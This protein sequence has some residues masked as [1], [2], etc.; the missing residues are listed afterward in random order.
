MPVAF[1][2]TNL[3][4]GLD[5]YKELQEKYSNLL[6]NKKHSYEEFRQIIFD[7][8]EDLKLDLSPYE[9]NFFAIS[10]TIFQNS[11]RA[12]RVLEKPDRDSNVLHSIS[13][14]IL[15]K[16]FIEK[17]DTKFAAKDIKNALRGILMHDIGEI[18]AEITTQND[19][20][21]DN[22]ITKPEKDKI[23]AQVFQIFIPA[24]SHLAQ[25]ND[26]KL[27][28]QIIAEVTELQKSTIDKLESNEKVTFTLIKNTWQELLQSE[29]TKELKAF[30]NQDFASNFDFGKLPYSRNDF[31]NLLNNYKKIENYKNC[32]SE[33]FVLAKLLG[34]VDIYI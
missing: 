15:F 33:I 25:T 19:V 5:S 16:E 22:I 23:E 3:Y 14:C 9:K 17:N 8:S 7:F 24:I 1:N 13:A 12:R 4:S 32:G 28:N 11:F 2:T 20:N 34:S 29:G 26:F 10:F 27:I 31:L 30:L 18:I 21:R 6:H